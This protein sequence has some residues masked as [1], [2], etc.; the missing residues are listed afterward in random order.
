[1]AHRKAEL[2]T[3]RKTV[4]GVEV[5][6]PTVEGYKVAAVYRSAE[7]FEG[8]VVGIAHL[9]VVDARAAAHAAQG[10]AVDFLV[11]FEGISS[12]LDTHVREHTAVVRCI[13]AAVVRARTSF[14][15]LVACVVRCLAAKDEAAPVAGLSLALGLA[16]GED[17]GLRS[18]AFGNELAAA[19]HNQRTFRLLV[20]ADDGARLNGELRAGGHVDPALQRVGTLLQR[21]LAVEDQFLVAVADGVVV[22]EQVVGGAQ[23]AVGGPVAFGR[24]GYLV[25]V[26]A[27][28]ETERKTERRGCHKRQRL[29]ENGSFHC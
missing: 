21:L 25:V 28:G 2:H 1:M 8:V 14:N 27:G 15:L 26:G 19:F 4:V 6:V 10:K 7:P 29:E 24:G 23:A 5:I 9:Y 22:K 18:G 20:A 3:S 17:D 11:R 16:R 13:R 12:K